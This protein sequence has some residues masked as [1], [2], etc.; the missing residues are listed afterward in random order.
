MQEKRNF[1]REPPAGANFEFD[2]ATAMPVITILMK[3]DP[4]L[5]KLRFEL[6]P[7]VYANS[8]NVVAR[9]D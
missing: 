2:L 9:A 1:T 4:N 7:K 5:D 6:V 3:E 8:P